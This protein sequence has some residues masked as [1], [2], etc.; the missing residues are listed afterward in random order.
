MRFPY[1]PSIPQKCGQECPAN[2]RFSVHTGMEGKHGKHYFTKNHG[3]VFFSREQHV[4]QF[5]ALLIVTICQKLSPGKISGRIVP[6]FERQTFC[7][8]F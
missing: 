3:G 7:M 4:S 1:F 6:K 8:G 5:K 2:T